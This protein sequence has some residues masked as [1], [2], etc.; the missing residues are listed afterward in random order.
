MSDVRKGWKWFEHEDYDN[1]FR[2]NMVGT[3]KHDV[4]LFKKI[5]AKRD[6]TNNNKEHVMENGECANC[7][8]RE[9]KAV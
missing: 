9:V 5:K 3:A 1:E 7:Y 2:P 8:Y 6:C 4:P